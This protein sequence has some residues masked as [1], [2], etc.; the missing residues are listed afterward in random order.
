M[1]SQCNSPRDVAK[2][3]CVISHKSLRGAR[4]MSSFRYPFKQSSFYD[5]VSTLNEKKMYVH[6]LLYIY[7]GREQQ[8]I[9]NARQLRSRFSFRRCFATLPSSFANWLS[10]SRLLSCWMLTQASHNTFQHFDIIIAQTE[11]WTWRRSESDSQKSLQ[12]LPV[13]WACC[14]SLHRTLLPHPLLS[15]TTTRPEVDSTEWE[16]RQL[17]AK[18]W[19]VL[20]W[21]DLRSWCGACVVPAPAT[22]RREKE[23]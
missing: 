22:N 1:R 3:A 13:F 9:L 8:N 19:N 10:H 14:I 6:S 16:Q 5:D 15:N 2:C 20:M 11:V 4:K 18:K 17:V 21:R 7:I 23:K 12:Q